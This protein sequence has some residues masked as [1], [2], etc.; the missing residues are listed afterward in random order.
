MSSRRDSAGSRERGGSLCISQFAE[1]AEAVRRA[2]PRCG[3]VRLVAI[4]GPGGAGKSVFAERL[5]RSLGGVPVIHTD[6]F[7]SWDDP[8]GWWPR[9][10]REVLAPL[11]QGQPVTFQAYDWVHRRLGE[12][13]RIRASDV[14]L[15]EGVSS[16]RQAVAERLSLAVWIETPSVECLT[17]GLARDG[18][19]M[20]QQWERWMAEEEAHFALDRTWERAHVIVDGAPSLPH[21]PESEFVSLP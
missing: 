12:W 21:D 3:P 15:V 13:R 5:A 19:A 18:V 14:V 8:R 6:D 20:R 9:L 11:E 7:A 4:D 1:L 10:E 2:L 16:A 17:R